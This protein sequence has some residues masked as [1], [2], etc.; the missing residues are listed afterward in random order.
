MVNLTAEYGRKHLDHD[1][2]NIGNAKTGYFSAANSVKNLHRTKQETMNGKQENQCLHLVKCAIVDCNGPIYDLH[3]SLQYLLVGQLGGVRVWPLRPLIKGHI[4]SKKKKTSKVCVNGQ[5]KEHYNKFE[6]AHNEGSKILEIPEFGNKKFE[7]SSE[8]LECDS[9]IVEDIGFQK[10]L[11][12]QEL[13]SIKPKNGLHDVDVLENGF[14][15]LNLKTITS[16]HDKS[17]CTERKIKGQRCNCNETG[18]VPV[19]ARLN[20]EAIPTGPN[21]V[22][23]VDASSKLSYRQKGK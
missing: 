2:D 13:T 20:L 9:T 7:V 3:V 4:T 10:T 21:G 6:T 8:F 22:M 16:F 23:L 11:K 19:N 17:N 18:S 5:N 1:E 15:V 14:M 12:R